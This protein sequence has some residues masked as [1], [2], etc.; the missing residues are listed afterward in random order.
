MIMRSDDRIQNQA[1]VATNLETATV[2]NR[3][4]LTSMDGW[5]LVA[6]YGEHP[7]SDGLQRINSD[8]AQRMVVRW[9]DAGRPEL[10]VDFDHRTYTRPDDTE[11]AGWINE[12]EARSNGLWAHVRWTDAGEAALR[13]G[14]Y[15]QLSP[16]WS[17][18]TVDSA[19][20]GATRIVEPV[21]LLNIALT[22]QPNI[23][24]LPMLSNQRRGSAPHNNQP[25][26]HMKEILNALGLKPEATENE[27]VKAIADLK[28]NAET[29]QNRC[30]KLETDVKSQREAQVEADLE[31]YKD[32]I[33]DTDA[34]RA[35]LNHDRE[36][37]VK[38]FAAQAKRMQD[39]APLSNRFPARHPEGGQDNRREPSASQATQQAELVE[40]IRL[41]NRCSF[42]E[43]WD[44]ARREQPKL[45]TE[46]QEEK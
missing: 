28:A 24:G 42:N 7:H 26:I 34:A 12:I 20:N 45:F 40:K 5:I 9:D 27:A 6:P 10:P 39:N 13:G 43:A 30:T 33:D 19:D 14:R 2:H 35:L 31:A 1:Q 21:E 46:N 3:F 8:V 22:N 41:S 17:I 23:R 44:Q 37:A 16:T 4:E 32:V 36:A 11:S 25:E 15:R 18:R 38:I 29:L